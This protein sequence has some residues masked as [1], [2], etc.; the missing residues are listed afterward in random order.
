MNDYTDTKNRVKKDFENHEA[1]IIGRTDKCTIIDWQNRNGSG[2]NRIRY[3][4]DTQQ[5]DIVITGDLGTAVFSWHNGQPVTNLLGYAKDIHYF[6]S[7]AV[8]ATDLFTFDDNDVI[9]DL[10]EA[11]RKAVEDSEDKYWS[12][13][14]NNAW[15]GLVEEINDGNYSLIDDDIL[16]PHLKF[17]DCMMEF[18]D[19]FD[20][21]WY[22][23]AE[24]CYAG[25]RIAPRV[26]YWAAGLLGILDQ[27]GGQLK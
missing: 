27:I 18:L 13:E 26:F 19:Y 22:E 11:C 3:I 14:H 25:K 23:K 17:S 2:I 6:I 21:E 20:D 1:V 8:T 9:K 16:N 5:G 12:S 7:K 10:E 4:F 24:F 15:E